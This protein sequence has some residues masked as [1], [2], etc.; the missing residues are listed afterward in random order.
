MDSEATQLSTFW[1]AYA[2]AEAHKKQV[3][4]GAAAL[5]VVG[6]VIYFVIWQRAEKEAA[7]NHALS[8]VHAAQLGAGG[9]N[10]NPDAYLKIAAEF[11]ESDA[12]AR[13]LLLGAGALFAESKFA[14]A[15]AQF[16]KFTRDYRESPFVG[17]ALLGIAASLEA[18]GKTNEAVNAYKELI[19]RRPNEAVTPQAKFALANLY[20]A[21]AKPEQAKSLFEDLTRANP[22]GSLGSEAGIR[23][24]ELLAKHP[25]LV[26][27]PAVTSLTL[28]ITT[29]LP[30]PAPTNPSPSV[31]TSQAPVPVETK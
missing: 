30:A 29:N 18:Q 6:L 8:M 11:P 27:P 15:Q 2:W 14:E 12:A 13:A 23:L 31:S 20:E 7:A 16:Q 25:N 5:L 3:S 26:T 22:Y 4:Y 24:E 10:P 21:Q 28:P 17:Q 9:G 19:E 1:K